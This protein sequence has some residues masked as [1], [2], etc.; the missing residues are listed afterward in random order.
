MII[1]YFSF[2]L[3]LI[4]S[5]SFIRTQSIFSNKTALLFWQFT[6]KTL[7][8]INLVSSQHIAIEMFIIRLLYL[9]E[10]RNTNNRD[11]FQ[12]DKFEKEQNFN[13]SLIHI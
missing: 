4:W 7:E 12:S 1:K 11:S 8:E 5:Y 6:I 9:K 2:L 13:L 10:I 3:G